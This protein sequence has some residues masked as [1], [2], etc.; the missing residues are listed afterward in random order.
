MMKIVNILIENLVKLNSDK[1]KE[2]IGHQEIKSL[3]TLFSTVR[4]IYALEC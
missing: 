1:E 2:R 3:K 4:S